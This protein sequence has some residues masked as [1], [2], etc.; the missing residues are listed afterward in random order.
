MVFRAAGRTLQQARMAGVF[1]PATQLNED[2]RDDNKDCKK[3]EQHND[4]RQVQNRLNPFLK[5]QKSPRLFTAHQRYYRFQAQTGG[6]RAK[7]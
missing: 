5:R 4:I 6:S 3:Y 7:S 2:R 1:A